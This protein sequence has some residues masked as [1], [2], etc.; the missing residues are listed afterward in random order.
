MDSIQFG[1]ELIG[2]AIDFWNKKYVLNCAVPINLNKCEIKENHESLL[3]TPFS[4]ALIKNDFQLKKKRTVL[5]PDV[6]H[7]STETSFKWLK[8]AKINKKWKKKKY[9][10]KTQPI[11]IY[12]A[13]D[14]DSNESK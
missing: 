9:A 6:A 13:Y 4:I 11:W 10:N 3:S 8:I 14:H 5:N 1:F 12:T 7:F 2:I